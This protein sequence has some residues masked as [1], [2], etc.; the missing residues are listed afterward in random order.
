MIWPMIGKSPTAS[1]S[2]TGFPLIE[3]HRTSA[4]F[5]ASFLRSAGVNFAMRASPDR[6][7]PLA[8]L[9]SFLVIKSPHVC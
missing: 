8:L 6:F 5:C 9:E 4:A 2:Y 3:A 1:G 7:F